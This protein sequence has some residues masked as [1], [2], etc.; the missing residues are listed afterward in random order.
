MPMY[1]I[2]Y[3]NQATS[4]RSVLTSIPSNARR[5]THCLDR[6]TAVC[7]LRLRRF[8]K[9]CR[10]K[11]FLASM[12]CATVGRTDTDPDCPR[13]S[14]RT[15]AHCSEPTVYKRQTSSASSPLC[16]RPSPKRP[17]T[18]YLPKLQTIIAS[19][20]RSANRMAYR[21]PSWPR[22]ISPLQNGR[23]EKRTTRAI[24]HWQ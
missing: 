3:Y 12:V 15:R 11:L 13:P 24:G 20:S 18:S 1:A 22:A 7:G 6:M 17:A 4:L 2:E 23:C 21:L 16:T 5:L 19:F 14:K 10:S 9:V 8:T